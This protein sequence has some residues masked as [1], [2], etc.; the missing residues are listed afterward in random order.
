MCHWR[1]VYGSYSTIRL[2][3]L[4]KTVIVVEERSQLG[5]HTGT[6]TDSTIG[7]HFDIGV[8]VQHDLPIVKDYLS[9]LNISLAKSRTADP[10]TSVYFDF[11]TGRPVPGYIPTDPTPGLIGYAAQLAKYPYLEEGFGELGPNVLLNSKILEVDR[12]SANQAKVLVSTPFSRTLLRCSKLVLTIPPKFDHL[13]GWDL[14]WSEESLFKQSNIQYNLTVINVSPKTEYQLAV[15]PGI[16][17]LSP[18][19][20]P[21]PLNC[22][23]GSPKALSD[24]EVKKKILTSVAGLQL[25][26][27]RPSAPELAVYSSHLPFELTVTPRAIAGGF[28]KRL[29][30][31]QGQRNTYFHCCRVPYP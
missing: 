19:G 21:D 29:Y 28:Y 30:E 8:T 2:S 12:S 3:E 7:S 1:G 17:K 20:I 23:S 9:Q 26:A 11:S 10:R 4:G 24:S 13:N 14:S 18:S 16:Y 22:K 15:L 31:L 25:P 6:H 5:S 27:K